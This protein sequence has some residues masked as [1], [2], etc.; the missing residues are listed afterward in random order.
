MR[1][2]VGLAAVA[3]FAVQPVMASAAPPAKSVNA[4]SSTQLQTLKLAMLQNGQG[5]QN[6]QGDQNA[7]EQAQCRANENSV[8]N[9]DGSCTPPRDGIPGQARRTTVLNGLIVAAAGT[10][11]LG[12]LLVALNR[13]NKK[14]TQSP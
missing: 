7:S 3:A 13:G 6:S 4:A 10:A 14:G 5:R 8:I 1:Y 11:A 2:F 12:G 9:A